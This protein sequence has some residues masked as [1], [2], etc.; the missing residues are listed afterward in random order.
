LALYETSDVPNPRLSFA[1]ESP[2]G[3]GGDVPHSNHPCVVKPWGFPDPFRVAPYREILVAAF[4]TAVGGVATSR[5]NLFPR[6]LYAPFA[7]LPNISGGLQSN[8][9]AT[10]PKQHCLTCVITT[11]MI[12]ELEGSGDVYSRR[13]EF[14][15]L[16]NTYHHHLAMFA[17]YMESTWHYDRESYSKNQEEILL[18]LNGLSHTYLIIT[19]QIKGKRGII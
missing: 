11:S 19:Q 3:R 18:F 1:V 2:G 13:T 17:Q 12:I 5:Y 10:N 6:S 8:I 15:C 16:L 14:L 4:V 7:S 9:N